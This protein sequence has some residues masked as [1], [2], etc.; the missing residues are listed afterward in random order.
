MIDLSAIRE[1]TPTEMP[2]I[3]L[4]RFDEESEADLRHLGDVIVGA[5][6]PA[7]SSFW[8]ATGCGATSSAAASRRR[9]SS[10]LSRPSESASSRWGRDSSATWL[11]PFT[12]DVF[13]V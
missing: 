2:V 3:D 7:V 11:L 1:A 12:A 5:S 13:T 6:E 10:T 8:S 4:S 9:A